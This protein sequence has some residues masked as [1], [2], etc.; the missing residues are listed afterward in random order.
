MATWGGDMKGQA[1]LRLEW[2]AVLVEQSRKGFLAEIEE[3]IGIFLD[4]RGE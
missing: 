2:G 1:W 4:E 3:M